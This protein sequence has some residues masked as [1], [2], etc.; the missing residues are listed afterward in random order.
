[1]AFKVLP[2]GKLLRLQPIIQTILHVDGA[3]V[4]DRIGYPASI[5]GWLLKKIY[6]KNRQILFFCCIKKPP[7]AALPYSDYMPGNYSSDELAKLDATIALR[8]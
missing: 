6:R 3:W 2:F 4:F 8:Y 5:E 7:I 1:M